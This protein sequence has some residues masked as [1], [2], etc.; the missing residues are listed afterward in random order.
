MLLKKYYQIIIMEL[1]CDSTCRW[2]VVTTEFA[3]TVCTCCG[4]V[5]KRQFK[6]DITPRNWLTEP[7]IN[8]YSRKKRFKTLAEALFWPSACAKDCPMI[9]YLTTKGKFNSKKELLQAIKLSNL[10]DKR[11]GK[12]HLFC[13]LFC[14]NYRVPRFTKDLH[15]VMII[16]LN[17]FHNIEFCFSRLFLNIQFFNYRYLLKKLL[18]KL[19]LHEYVPFVKTLKC[20]QRLKY[21]N[22]MFDSV[23]DY[24]KPL[25]RFNITL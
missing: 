19:K 7:L 23:Y 2:D 10:P 6:T 18:L 3:H 20:K 13:K 22:L 4:I 17:Q 5:Q 14:T 12:I 24:M 21:Y 1:C 15:H 25:D 11:Y 8:V 16:L 9:Q